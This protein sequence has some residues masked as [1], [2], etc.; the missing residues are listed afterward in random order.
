M[1]ATFTPADAE[2]FAA[3]LLGARKP[4]APRA[5]T[6]AKLPL[7]DADAYMVQDIVRKTLG[8]TEGWKVG[9]ANAT[10][11][12]NCAP[13]LKGGIIAAGS[14]GIPLSIPVPKPTGI[15]VEIAFRMAKAFPAAATAPSAEDI[16][17]G[18]GSAHV[19]MELCASRLAD[20]PQAPPKALLADSGMNLG[21]LM[22]PEVKDWRA[23]DAHKQV[24]RAWVDNK[25]A[26]EMTAGH[27]QKDLAALLVWLVGHVVT[28]RGG[29][30]AGSVVATG[31]WT[32]MHWVDH[33]A[34]VA[35]EFP[36]VGRLE[37]RLAM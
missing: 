11:P 34:N 37:A 23:V 1:T 6:P 3:V 18:I 29:L 13:V 22:G 27:T 25:A 14:A 7:T 15:E 28:K 19:A 35:A 4:G 9:A 16:L 24:A 32:G 12:P 8:P 30:P 33:A 20:G 21:F 26:V 17:A 31:S 36:G 5:A 2:A 10:S